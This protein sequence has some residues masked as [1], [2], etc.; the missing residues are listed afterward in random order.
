MPEDTANY[1]GQLFAEASGTSSFR[2]ECAGGV[3]DGG[4]GGGGERVSPPLSDGTQAASQLHYYLREKMVPS[5]KKRASLKPMWVSEVPE[6][7]GDQ[8]LVRPTQRPR[9]TKQT[10]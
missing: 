2:A 8:D 4:G 7:L 6:S 3:G 10:T 1:G 5:R 9:S